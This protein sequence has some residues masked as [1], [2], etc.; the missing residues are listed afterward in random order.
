MREKKKTFL[1]KSPVE[2]LIHPFFY[3]SRAGLCRTK[4]TSLPD[5]LV[6]RMGSVCS[7]SGGDGLR[8]ASVWICSSLP[9]RA[10][11][12]NGTMLV[13][14]VNIN[15]VS[16]TPLRCPQNCTENRRLIYRAAPGANVIQARSTDTSVG[17]CTVVFEML[18]INRTVF[19][20]QPG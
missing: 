12:R 10:N 8:A 1:K 9:P 4:S 2:K 6:T 18:R 3:D 13:D 20:T 17:F 11:T 19:N 5:I 15:I 16:R 7:R 14:N